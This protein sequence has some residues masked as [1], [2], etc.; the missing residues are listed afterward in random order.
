[1]NRTAN[2]LGKAP[3]AK[4]RHSVAGSRCQRGRGRAAAPCCE[5][6]SDSDDGAVFTAT[7]SAVS[8]ECRWTVWSRRGHRA[9]GEQKPATDD[10]V[11]HMVTAEPYIHS[12][13]LPLSFHHNERNVLVRSRAISLRLVCIFSVRIRGSAATEPWRAALQCLRR[14]GASVCGSRQFCL[15]WRC[16]R[17]PAL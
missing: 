5:R 17:P 8:S 15:S 6:V 1:M 4:D 10:E 7:A 14:F 3:C 12:I 9:N 2:P 13:L 16:F 11:W